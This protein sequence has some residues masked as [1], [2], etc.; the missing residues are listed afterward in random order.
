MGSPFTRPGAVALAASLAVSTHGQQPPGREAATVFETEV[1]LVALPVFVFDKTG[2]AVPGLQASDFEIEEQGR[3]VPIVAFQAVDAAD[4]EPAAPAPG[5]PAAVQAAARRQFVFLFDLQFAT[6]FGI[7]RAR[8]AAFDF[9]EKSMA[10]S[11]LA[12]VATYGRGG[13]KVLTPLGPDRARTAR[14]V[15]G[16]GLTQ[17][18]EIESDPLDMIGSERDLQASPVGSDLTDPSLDPSGDLADRLE[19]QRD[20][21]FMNGAQ[22]YQQRVVDYLDQIK[23][24]ARLL[25]AARG[26][27]QLVLFS[28]G[29]DPTTWRVRFWEAGGDVVIRSKMDELFRELAAADTVIHALDVT[30]LETT[31]SV[32]DGLRA[33]SQGQQSLAA[34]TLNSGGRLIKNT[35][36]LEGGLR[37]VFDASRYYYV[38]AFEP[39]DVE[40]A[41][42][43]LTKLKV[44][45]AREGLTVSHRSGYVLP[46]PKA[47]DANTRKM[48]ASEAIAKGLSGGPL[49]LRV[50]ALPYR[51]KDG[52]LAVSAVLEL[53]PSALPREA[54]GGELKLE[55]YGYAVTKGRV[56]DG[57]ALSPVLSLPKLGERVRRTGVQVL[58]S[59]GAAEGPVELRFFVR[60]AAAPERWG[61]TRF[62]L[63]VPGFGEGELRALPPLAMQDPAGR[64]VIPFTSRG[65]PVEIPFRVGAQRFVP[66]ALPALS[67]GK[68]REL[69]ALVW[70]GG[71]PGERPPLEVTAELLEAEGA[72]QPLALAGEARVAPD[73]DGFER[74]VVSVA[75]PEGVRG[76]RT[77]RLAFRDPA[78]ATVAQSEAI[79]EVN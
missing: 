74:Y 30:G 7:V 64:V 61:A 1:T 51:A 40:R 9:I 10:P 8:K 34:L 14:A 11:D 71:R 4:E 42:K 50:L 58:A 16:L 66:E 27:K 69:C 31:M 52:G 3:K 35:N 41:R 33:A 77:L 39:T 15:L 79:V 47:A 38:L 55:I 73:A 18:A 63:G 28:A 29:F 13:L 12:A 70:R 78:A 65:R 75:V 57:V 49:G 46:D 25:G 59:L 2:K 60:D 26:R 48:Q 54:P 22:F 36:D 5:T 45:V 53:D 23:A 67:A 37:E 62:A 17:T 20:R 32:F 68:S 72:A 56:L 76:E 6:P 44:R 21:N 24:L 43:R 19:V